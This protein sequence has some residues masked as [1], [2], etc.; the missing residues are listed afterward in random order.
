MVS[1]IEV[2]GTAHPSTRLLQR[3]R[4]NG[5]WGGRAIWRQALKGA[6]REGLVERRC[7]PCLNASVRRESLKPDIEQ[8]AAPRFGSKHFTADFEEPA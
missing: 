4:P 6:R 2:E 5:D 7:R 8:E 1:P 3:A